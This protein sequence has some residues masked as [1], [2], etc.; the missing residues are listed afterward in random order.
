MK[1]YIVEDDDIISILLK[2]ELEKWNYEVFTTKDF[3]NI[4]S[5]FESYSP[6]LVLMD[7]NL[8]F[9]NGYYWCQEIRKISNVPI[10]FISSKTDNMDIVMA[11]QF[12][13]DDYITKPISID[14]L[15]AKVRA[16]LRRSYEFTTNIDYLSYM[17]TRLILSE[18]S[19]E[20][21]GN[22][23]S[24]TKTEMLILEPLFKAQGRIVSK[25]GLIDNCWQ[26]NNFIDDNTLAVNIARLR[27]KL[28]SI[29]LDKFIE[30]KKGIG[31]F[32]SEM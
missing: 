10:V 3:N 24:I 17:D 14:V 6:Q 25:E 13:G 21:R 1:I 22:K 28:S 5:E 31:Y 18:A 7:I 12:G 2:S 15:I 20:Y 26:S 9:Y 27:K 32:L 30:T 8:P 23:I 29:G 16:I 19:L 4:V 11:M